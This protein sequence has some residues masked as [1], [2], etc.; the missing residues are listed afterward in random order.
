MTARSLAA[1]MVQR[2]RCKT[3]VPARLFAA[4]MVWR[5]VHTDPQKCTFD[6]FHALH[7]AQMFALHCNSSFNV[8]H[9]FCT[10]T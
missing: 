1:C 8:P 7:A 5:D 6:M 4:C 9:S 2:K 3:T 10:H